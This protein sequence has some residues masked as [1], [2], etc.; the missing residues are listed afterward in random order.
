MSEQGIQPLPEKVTAIANL[1]EPNSMDE[2]CHFLGLTGYYRRFI[3]LFTDIAKTLNKLIKRTLSSSHWHI[4]S[5]LLS[6]LKRHFV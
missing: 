3:P 4:V 5:Q 1:K 6:I 2:L